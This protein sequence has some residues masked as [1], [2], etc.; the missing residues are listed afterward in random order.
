MKDIGIG[1]LGHADVRSE[2]YGSEGNLMLG[3]GLHRTDLTICSTS[4]GTSTAFR[5]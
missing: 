3:G 4:K 1:L 5:K 2:V